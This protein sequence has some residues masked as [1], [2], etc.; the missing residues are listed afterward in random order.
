MT[1][2]YLPGLITVE[3]DHW[4]Q[5][6]SAGRATCSA[7]HDGLRHRNIVIHVGSQQETKVPTRAEEGAG[8]VVSR[9]DNC[10]ELPGTTPTGIREGGL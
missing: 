2:G 6:L 7:L 9:H 10:L 3:T 5:V 8:R 4:V 1:P